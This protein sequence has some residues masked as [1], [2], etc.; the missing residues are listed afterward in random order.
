MSNRAA[1][2]VFLGIIFVLAAVLT[3]IEGS[4]VFLAR[5]FADLLHLVAF[6]R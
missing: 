3:Q 4:G 1:L 6:W 5:K 2:L